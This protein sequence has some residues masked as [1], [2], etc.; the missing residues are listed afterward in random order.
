MQFCC[1]EVR[2]LTLVTLGNAKTSNSGGSIWRQ[3][4][5]AQLE[6]EI[7]AFR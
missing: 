4:M 2:P 5:K 1:F 7:S 6:S 3:V